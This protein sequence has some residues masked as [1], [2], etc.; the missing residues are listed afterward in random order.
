MRK[1]IIVTGPESSG[2]TTLSQQLA[3]K[4][5]GAW[6]PEYAR[7]YL[8]AANRKAIPSDFPHLVKATNSLVEAGFEQQERIGQAPA[9]VIQDTGME[10]LYVWQHDKFKSTPLVAAAFADSMPDV[11]ILCTPDLPWENDPLREDP[12]RRQELFLEIKSLLRGTGFP[13][14]EVS[15]F[16]ESRMKNILK[17]IEHYLR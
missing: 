14:I 3:E 1:H 11:Y 17:D 16:G 5:G 4:L 10:V 15:G 12:H 8:Q 13:V 7:G 6:I 2:K 9:L